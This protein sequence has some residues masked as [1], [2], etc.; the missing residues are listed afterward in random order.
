ML[1]EY[2]CRHQKRAAPT[3]C[4]T[5]AMR[6]IQ[7]DKFREMLQ[8]SRQTSLRE[9]AGRTTTPSDDPARFEAGMAAATAAVRSSL[10]T[11]LLAGCPVIR[12]AQCAG[13][14]TTPV[15][16]AQ[17]EE[18]QQHAAVASHWTCVVGMAIAT[19]AVRTFACAFACAA[20]PSVIAPAWLMLAC[21][22]CV[23]CDSLSGARRSCCIRGL[24]CV[25]GA[26][27]GAF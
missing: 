22:K 26:C 17:A 10:P 18:A 11:A 4:H 8:E 19:A 16:S 23:P 27:R 25:C 12:H 2:S 1:A 6:R 5:F 21:A 3:H 7:A 20:S 13:L 9:L 14:T 24:T 15:R